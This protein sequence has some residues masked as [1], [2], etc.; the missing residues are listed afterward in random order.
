MAAIGLLPKLTPV[1]LPTYAPWLN[2]IEKLWKRLRQEVLKLHRLSGDWKTLRAK[3]REYLSKFAEG[4]EALLRYVGLKGEG[5][6][7][8]ALQAE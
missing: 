6:L 2:P 4:S 3:V 5:K 1:W 7:A 8:Q